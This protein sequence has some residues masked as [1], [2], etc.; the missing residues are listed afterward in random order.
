M[1]GR[2]KEK[3]TALDN[4][5]GRTIPTFRKEKHDRN[6]ESDI[7]KGGADRRGGWTGHSPQ[8][9]FRVEPLAGKERGI[10]GGRKVRTKGP[11]DIAC[12]EK[13]KGRIRAIELLGRGNICPRNAVGYD[14]GAA[15][16]GNPL[17]KELSR[18][19]KHVSGEGQPTQA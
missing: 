11:T 3:I 13:R 14:T 8:N 19:E 1:E 4:L 5:K 10:R 7:E 12:G 6:R 18:T 17:R 16:P 2:G 9:P 15:D